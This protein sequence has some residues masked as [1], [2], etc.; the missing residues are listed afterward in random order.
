MYALLVL[1]CILTEYVTVYMV[2]CY[3]NG[4]YVYQCYLPHFGSGFFG[5]FSFLSTVLSYFTS[6]IGEFFWFL[7]W[8]FIYLRYFSADRCDGGR[9]MCE[10][11]CLF[12]W[13]VLVDSYSH[14]ASEIEYGLCAFPSF[15]V[16]INGEPQRTS[17]S[18]YSYS[19]L[20]AATCF[21]CDF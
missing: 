15:I 14:L 11:V 13:Y 9:Y 5:V 6:Y 7:Y 17:M 12:A 20:T 10:N 1:G 2:A 18:D 8:S 21:S 16:S 4:F 19:T 3:L